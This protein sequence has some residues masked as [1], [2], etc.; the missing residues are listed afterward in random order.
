MPKT[1]SRPFTF[2]KE[3]VFYFSRRIPKELGD[4]YTSSRIAFSLRTKSAKIAETRAR[5]TNAN[6]AS[7][8]LNKWMKMHVPA[9]C[10]MHG[11][12][13]AILHNQRIG[14]IDFKSDVLLP[15]WLFYFLRTQRALVP[16]KSTSTG[17]MVRHTAPKR[18]LSLHIPVPSDLDEQQNAIGRLDAVEDEANGLQSEYQENIDDLVDRGAKILKMR[19]E[20]KKQTIRQRRL[21]H[22]AAAA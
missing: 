11:F 1:I 19:E 5:K 10:T 3:G 12:R 18:I 4:H 21:Q 17:S 14:R 6:A 7:A 2:V 8:A 13:H 22:Q 16:I 9:G 15:R 20:I